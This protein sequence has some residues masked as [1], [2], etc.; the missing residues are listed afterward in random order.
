MTVDIK[1]AKA[2]WFAQRQNA[3][4]RGI[5]FDFPFESWLQF[6][7]DSGHW[8]ERGV[9]LDGYVMSR[10]GDTGPYRIDNVEIKKN[11]ENLSEGNLGKQKSIEARIKMSDWQ[12]GI[13]R[14]GVGGRKPGFQWTDEYR[15]AFIESRTGHKHE[16]K[17]CEYCN[18]E[19][20]NNVFNRWHGE[21]CKKKPTEVGF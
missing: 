16:S 8:H 13:K 7:L 17:T 21:N 6:W 20:A 12:K 18:R 5:E 3:R 19:I 4:R 15:K 11:I 14:P 10:K 9:G 2:K 1:Q